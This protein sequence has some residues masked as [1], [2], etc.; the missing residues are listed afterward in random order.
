LLEDPACGL[1]LVDVGERGPFL[2]LM[3]AA[4]VE[5]RELDRI[6]GLDYS[7]GKRLELILYAVSPSG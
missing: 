3:T 7:N 2:S 4:R 1:A 5:P 6:R